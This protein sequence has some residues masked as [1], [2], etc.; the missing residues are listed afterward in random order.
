MPENVRNMDFT[1]SSNSNIVD[2]FNLVSQLPIKLVGSHNLLLGRP[3]ILCSCTGT[4]CLAILIALPPTPSTTI[5]QNNRVLLPL[6]LNLLGTMYLAYANKSQTQ[7]FSLHDQLTRLTKDS[8]PVADY[9]HQVLS[10]YNEL[11]T[12]GAT[13][14]NDKLVV[15]IL[16]GLGFDFSE[17]S[18]S[19][20]ARDYIISYD[21]L[22][23]K[24]IVYELFLRHEEVKK[25]TSVIT[26]PIVTRNR[27]IYS[28]NR[29]ARRP[30]N[31][32]QWCSSNRTTAPAQGRYINNPV[33]CQLCNK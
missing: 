20:R 14:T 11:N 4:I 29:A 15:K 19:I 17:I 31:T 21:E 13:I 1:T 6:L 28:N 10:L 32:S 27:S 16:S 23:E 24:L 22:Y 26:A 12:A 5:T 25:E 30:N 33:H 9:L 8:H 7:I 18:T 3:E 2:Q